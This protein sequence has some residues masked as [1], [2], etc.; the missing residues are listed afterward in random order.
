MHYATPERA[1][2]LAGALG[3]LPGTVWLVGC[4]PRDADRL[5]EGLSDEVA[6]AV[7]SAVAE[8]A[9]LLA[10]LGLSWPKLAR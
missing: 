5:G 1:L 3:V 8:V 7:D 2:M 9:R 10:D 6:A 4:Q